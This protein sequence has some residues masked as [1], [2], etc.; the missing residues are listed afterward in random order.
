MDCITEVRNERLRFRNNCFDAISCIRKYLLS[1]PDHRLVMTDEDY[2]K[3]DEKITTCLFDPTNDCS[4]NEATIFVIAL[5]N[6]NHIRISGEYI[7]GKNG[8][9]GWADMCVISN[10]NISDVLDFILLCENLK[11]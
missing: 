4:Y 11:K 8:D 2:L 7:D 9:N 6:D 10:I 1:K 5:D 3:A